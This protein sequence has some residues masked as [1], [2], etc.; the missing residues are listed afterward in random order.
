MHGF[1]GAK[2][3]RVFEKKAA[4]CKGK[5]GDFLLFEKEDGSAQFF[6]LSDVKSFKE[7][8]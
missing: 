2:N 7:T 6:H 1:K 8:Y 3:T 4:L 5:T